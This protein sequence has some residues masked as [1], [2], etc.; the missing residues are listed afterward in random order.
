MRTISHFPDPARKKPVKRSRHGNVGLQPLHLAIALIFHIQN[1]SLGVPVFRHLNWSV[2]SLDADGDDMQNISQLEHSHD[3][4]SIS[5]FVDRNSIQCINYCED[6]FWR[7]VVPGRPRFRCASAISAL[8]RADA[9]VSN[10][11]YRKESGEMV[12][13]SARHI[14]LAKVIGAKNRSNGANSLDPVCPLRLIKIK[15][16]SRCNYRS[17]SSSSKKGISNHSRLPVIRI[18]CHMGILS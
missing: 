10:I 16:Q 9:L 5:D 11:A 18:N 17:A 12:T 1:L 7:A 4:F 2:N 13:L 14:S 6:G 15:I 3:C 8:N